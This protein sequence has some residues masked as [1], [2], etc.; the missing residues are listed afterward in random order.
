MQFG[1]EVNHT[2]LHTFFV[3][4]QLIKSFFY[5]E[6]LAN[7]ATNTSLSLVEPTGIKSWVLNSGKTAESHHLHFSCLPALRTGIYAFCHFVTTTSAMKD[8]GFLLAPGQ[9]ENQHSQQT[10]STQPEPRLT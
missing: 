8:H 3:Q 10:Q 9:E 4:V 5:G 7:S 6:V 2:S 1:V